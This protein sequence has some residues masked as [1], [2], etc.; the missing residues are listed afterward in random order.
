MRTSMIIFTTALIYTSTHLTGCTIASTTNP[1]AHRVLTPGMKFQLNQALEILPEKAAVYIQH[2]KIISDKQ[3]EVYQP[4]CRFVVHGLDKKSRNIQPDIFSISKISF[5]TELV[6][7]NPAYLASSS[8]HFSL[9]T[10]DDGGATAEIYTTYFYLQSEN[11][12]LVS[13]ISCSHWED[14][15]DG[16]YLTVDQISATLGNII[17]LKQ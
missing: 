11:Q 3:I 15:T 16:S 9:T 14:A 17:E 4:N 7:K 8:L 1:P 5:G 12:P 13:H 6:M 2:G 10:G